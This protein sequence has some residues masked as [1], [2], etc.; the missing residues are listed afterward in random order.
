MYERK[1]CVQAEGASVTSDEPGPLAPLPA[2]RDGRHGATSFERHCMG[3]GLKDPA[4][5]VPMLEKSQY[6]NQM[7]RPVPPQAAT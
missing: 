7:I 6:Q 2:Q 3:I 5:N 1:I 4:Q